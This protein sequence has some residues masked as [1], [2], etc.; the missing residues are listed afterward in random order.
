MEH[1]KTIACV[2]KVGDVEQMKRNQ[3]KGAP[4][5]NKKGDRIGIINVENWAI[6]RK[7]VLS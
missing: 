3:N 7:N 5:E 1:G 6:L 4:E 2:M